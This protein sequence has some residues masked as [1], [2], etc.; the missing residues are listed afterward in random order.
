MYF[1]SFFLAA[2]FFIVSTISWYLSSSS[3]ISILVCFFLVFNIPN[4]LMFFVFPPGMSVLFWRADQESSH[5][6][7]MVTIHVDHVIGLSVLHISQVC[8][9]GQNVVNFFFFSFWRNEGR[10]FMRRLPERVERGV[11]V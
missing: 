2:A 3:D 10:L 4:R 6:T 8:S 9:L 1:I 7:S 11:I 5:D